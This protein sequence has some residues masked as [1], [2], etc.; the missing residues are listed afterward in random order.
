MV[1]RIFSVFTKSAVDVLFMII[2]LIAGS[3]VAS[4]ISYGV[5]K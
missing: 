3:T 1:K 4:L 2:L 5:C